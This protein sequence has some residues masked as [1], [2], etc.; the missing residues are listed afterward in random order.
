MLIEPRVRVIRFV[1]KEIT[2]MK[3]KKIIALLT[4]AAIMGALAGCQAG[5]KPGPEAPAGESVPASFET[6]APVESNAQQAVGRVTSVDGTKITVELGEL[7]SRTPGN[8]GGNRKNRSDDG[9]RTRPSGTDNRGSRTGFGYTFN[10]TGGSK[11]FD[12]SGLK[13]ITIENDDDDTSDTIEEIKS[14]DVVVIGV[15]KDGNVTF[16]TVKALNGRF[17]NRDRNRNNGNGNGNGSR[18]NRENGNRRS[19]KGDSAD[20]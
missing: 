5:S 9:S 7:K 13:Q 11:T 14:G 6:E 10:A 17:G 18:K 8:G 15:G 1:K 4:A 12:L 20:A 3:Y 16:L 2:S 19:E